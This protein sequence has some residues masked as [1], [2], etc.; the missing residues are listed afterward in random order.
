LSAAAERPVA[1]RQRPTIKR[2]ANA[3]FRGYQ[4]LG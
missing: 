2:K 4:V 1:I 3:G